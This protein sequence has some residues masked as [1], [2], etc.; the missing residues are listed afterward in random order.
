MKKIFIS[1]VLLLGMTTSAFAQQTWNLQK[2]IDYAIEHN[3]TIKQQ[4]D[5]V[6][7]QRISLS[8][9]KNSR[10]PDLSAGAG[11]SFGFGRA[12]TYDNTY[13]NRNTQGTSFNVSTSV[14]LITGGRIPAEIKVRKLG[15]EAALKDLS[16][17][18]ENIALQIM[19]A[20]LDVIYQRD[21][22]EVAKRQVELSNAQVK[23]SQLLFDNNKQSAAD[24]AQIKSTNATDVYSLS[25]QE[26]SYQLSLLTLSQLLELENTEGLELETPQITDISGIVLPSPEIVYS[27]ALGI[28]PQIAAEEIR[29]K[30]AQKSVTVA[31]S[32]LYPTLYFSAGMGSNYYKT[33]G[34]P[35][36]SFGTQLKDNFNQSLSFNLSVPIFNRFQTRNSIRSAQLSVHTQQIQLEKSRKSLYKEIQ[37]AYYSALGSQK[38]SV[39]ADVSLASSQ[40]AFSLMQKKYENGK[41]TVTE[42]EQAK[43]NL[44]KAESTSIYQKYTFYFRQKILEFYRTAYDK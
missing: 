27:E 10:L 29:L 23:R 7:Q 12:L 3:L 6:E 30:S 14:P 24:L 44:E 13:A 15:L 22:V 21:L 33:S 42:F 43:T 8:T 36:N 37:Q 9:A 2:C 41:A 26:N 39:S 20:Y 40:E 16:A 19:S 35:S 25:S 17:A 4:E 31:K 18:R 32:A 11:Q 5:V 38:Q 34:F 28:K 1:A